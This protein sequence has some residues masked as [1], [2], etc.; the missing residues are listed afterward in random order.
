[1][2][3]RGVFEGVADTFVAGR[4]HSLYGVRSEDKWPEC[5]KCTAETEDGI[6]MALQ[7]ESYPMAAV[8]FHPESIMTSYNFAVRMITNVMT[9]LAA[10]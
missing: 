10:K 1:M 6:C 2:D 7:H 9:K 8:Q 3:T 5:L 4:Y